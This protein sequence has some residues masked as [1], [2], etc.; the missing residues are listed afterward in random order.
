M[1]DRIFLMCGIVV[2]LIFIS[3]FVI[4]NQINEELN[5]TLVAF[6]VSENADLGC[7][8]LLQGGTIYR[9]FGIIGGRS[10][11]RQSKIGVRSDES[12]AA[13]YSVK[14][15]DSTEWLI[16][17]DEGFMTVG[18]ILYK[19]KDVQEIPKELEKYKEYDF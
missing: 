1:K 7:V 11:L 5:P 14:G 12:Q 16:E 10:S 8:E 6:Q 15:F 9:I 18:D 19:S 17:A 2:V 13:I 3:I 4:L